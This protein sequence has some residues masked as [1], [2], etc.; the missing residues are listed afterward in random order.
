[1]DSLP[2]ASCSHGRLKLNC[3]GLLY[4]QILAFISMNSTMA[5]LKRVQLAVRK[6]VVREKL[7]LEPFSFTDYGDVAEACTDHAYMDT[8]KENK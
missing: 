3:S 6:S 5:M 2:I 8:A 4:I 7:L 1:M